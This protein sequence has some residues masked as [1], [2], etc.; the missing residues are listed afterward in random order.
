MNELT[1]E[2]FRK[3]LTKICNRGTSQDPKGWTQENLLWG[4]CAA[5]SLIAQNLFGGELLRDDLAKVPRFERIGSHY[6]NRLPNGIVYDFTRAQ[7]GGTYPDGLESEVKDRAYVLSHPDTVRR[8]KLLALRLAKEDSC[9]NRIFDDEIY[10]RCFYAALDSPCQKMKF[11]CV[12]THYGKIVYEGCNKTI[13]P[14]RS[15]C[16]PRCVRFSIP[17]RTESMLGA[18]GHAEEGIWEVIHDGTVISECELYYCGLFANGLSWLKGEAEHTCLRCS[19]QMYN[20]RL[21][22]IYA[23]VI[24]KW[25]G[26]TPEQALRSALLYATKQKMV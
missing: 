6:F 12:I 14:L 11:G 20:A 7:F 13:E 21:G 24:D 22:A 19:T 16:E 18:C 2:G 15:I 17:S 9:G 5:V 26:I 10:Q 8:Y 25:V 23:P 1:P 3:I 4:H